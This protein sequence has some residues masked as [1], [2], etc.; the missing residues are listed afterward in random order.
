MSP[1]W[2][3]AVLALAVLQG[4]LVALPAAGSLSRLCRLRSPAWAAVLP[5]SILVGTFAPLWHPSL[6]SAIV[7]LAALATPVLALVA[8]VDVARG[9]GALLIAA[10]P[11]L[12][13]AVVL[14]PGAI[15]DVAASIVTAFGC[16]AAGVA[17][18]RLIPRG[19]LVAAIGLM[20]AL[21]VLLLAVGLGEPAALRIAD[22]AARF[23]GHAFA[24]ATIGPVTTD[25]P[26]LVLA[27]VVGGLLAGRPLQRRAAAT[28][29]L[30]ATAAGMLLPVI[31]MVPST[32]PIALTFASSSA[33]LARARANAAIG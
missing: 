22:A 15:G 3:P 33:G 25:Y 30:L 14:A 16:M 27:G 32:I 4:S 5:G 18:T 12:V 28:L 19:W 7:L 17:L 23:H 8:A 9:R 26:D 31:H 1:P 11:A 21:D 24:A 29:T 20:C 13:L 10:A 6:A 2:I